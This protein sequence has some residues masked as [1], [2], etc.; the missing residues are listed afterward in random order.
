M[1]RTLVVKKI[2]CII[3]EIYILEKKTRPCCQRSYTWRYH[4]LYSHKKVRNGHLYIKEQSHVSG[5]KVNKSSCKGLYNYISKLIH[6]GHFSSFSEK[7][8]KKEQVNLKNIPAW[9]KTL[10]LNWP[11]KTLRSYGWQR[12]NFHFADSIFHDAVTILL[13]S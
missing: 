13:W 5:L 12:Y 3:E 4:N 6:T 11:F 9:Q 8:K 1:D 10:L 2:V 7:W